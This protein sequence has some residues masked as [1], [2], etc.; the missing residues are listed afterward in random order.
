M[1]SSQTLFD[2]K[3]TVNS[4]KDKLD[5]PESK[6]T[7][8]FHK[9]VA[10]IE[11][12]F[13]D[14]LGSGAFGTIYAGRFNGMKAAFKVFNTGKNVNLADL[15][16]QTEFM[17]QHQSDY[18]L[19]A[20][21]SE[22]LPFCGNPAVDNKYFIVTP[23]KK[24][25]FFKLFSA[26]KTNL[27]IVFQIIDQVA[28]GLQAMHA[29]CRV[30]LDIKMGNILLDNAFNAV[31]GDFDLSRK[32]LDK[33]TMHQ[34]VGTDWQIA[35][36]F[37]FN[38]VNMDLTKADV[39]SFGIMLTKIFFYPEFCKRIDKFVNENLRGMS[40]I[41]IESFLKRPRDNEPSLLRGLILDLTSRLP[42]VLSQLIRDCTEDNPQKRPAMQEVVLRLGDFLA[43]FHSDPIEEKS[44]E[45]LKQLQERL[46]DQE[47]LANND[48][49]ETLYGTFS[50]MSDEIKMQAIEL[51]KANIA[52]PVKQATIARL[53]K[54]FY[55]Y[56]TS[57]VM[58]DELTKLISIQ[59]SAATVNAAA[60]NDLVQPKINVDQLSSHN[61]A[62]FF[63]KFQ[64]RHV[65]RVTKIKQSH[66]NIVEEYLSGPELKL[67]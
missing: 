12:L 8:P 53:A 65:E 37:Y 33:Q 66:A 2:S 59:S 20:Y 23:L 38:R 63:R 16:E 24:C 45:F 31:I 25:D 67:T 36:E 56:A 42:I 52:D 28:L 17:M 26:G 54:E 29:L 57:D 49:I 5:V 7:K 46:K 34:I 30:H 41:D 44:K 10:K 11:F 43:K 22:T 14:V 21:A 58:L 27:V 47:Y 19:S 39:F 51:L 35:P 13:A 48:K 4:D 9:D 55:P 32:S 15:K 18:L 3:Q 6:T 1:A 40:A 64:S 61:Y 50:I 62:Y 60:N